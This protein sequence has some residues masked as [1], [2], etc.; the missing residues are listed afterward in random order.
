MLVNIS[1][2]LKFL[3]TLLPI[4]KKFIYCTVKET[5]NVK[6]PFSM[7]IK[8]N[9][10]YLCSVPSSLC[11]GRLR[12]VVSV[13]FLLVYVEYFQP[14]TFLTGSPGLPLIILNAE[15]R[16]TLSVRGSSHCVSTRHLPQTKPAV[17][18]LLTP[19]PE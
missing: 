16:A 3:S 4:F 15:R 5:N 13:V 17:R 18:P 9:G 6:N 14:R 7:K 11:Q 8:G 1:I 10:L 19:A 12:H 2:L